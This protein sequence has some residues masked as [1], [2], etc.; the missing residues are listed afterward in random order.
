MVAIFRMSCCGREVVSGRFQGIEGHTS[1]KPVCPHGCKAKHKGGI[2]M[3]FVEYK[4]ES[5]VP[6]ALMKTWKRGHSTGDPWHKY[7][8]EWLKR[9]EAESQGVQP[10]KAKRRGKK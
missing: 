1:H 10:D 8:R 2:P 5:M 9:K 6:E 7:N 3:Q 4:V